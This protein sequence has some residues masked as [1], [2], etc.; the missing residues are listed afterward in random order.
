M[1]KLT[2]YNGHYCEYEFENA[3]ITFLEDEGWHYLPGKSIG[4]ASQRDVLY[5]DDLEY[6]PSSRQEDSPEDLVISQQSCQE[7]QEAFRQLDP[8]YSDVLM[9]RYFHGYRNKE[10]AQLLDM[11]EAAVASRIFQGK[12][13][14]LKRLKKGGESHE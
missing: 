11:T 9:L 13:L 12:R 10:I 8:R 3:F 1:P 5:L 7:L 6:S 14:L 2:N 4:R